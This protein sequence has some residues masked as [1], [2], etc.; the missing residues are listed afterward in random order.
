MLAKQDRLDREP[1]PRAGLASGQPTRYAPRMTQGN[2]ALVLHAHLPFVRHPEHERFLEEH[3]LYEAVTDT[4]LPLLEIMEGWRRDGL[5]ARLTLSVSPTLGAMLLDPL[6]QE[7]TARHLQRLVTLAERERQRTRWEP[8]FYALAEGYFRR[9]TE[10]RARFEACGR[11]LMGGWRRLQEAGVLELMTTAATHAIL[12][13]LQSH[14]PSLRAQVRVA[15]AAHRAAFGA[16]PRGMWLPECAYAPGVDKELREAGVRWF[17]VDSHGLLLGEP[18]PRY[19]VFAPVF[20]PEGVA[21]FGR[22]PE[23]AK[24]VWSREEGYPGDGRYRDFYR[25]IGFDLDLD[26]LADVLPAPGTRS[27]TG[28]KYH[29]VTGR[30]AEKRPYDR[31]AAQIAVAE[32][33]R[34]FVEARVAQVERLAGV[35]DRP[36]MLVAPYDAELF[37]HWWHEGLE[38]L[39]AVVRRFCQAERRVRLVT[40]SEFLRDHPTQQISQPAAS[41]WGERGHLGVWVNESNAWILPHLHMAQERMTELAGRFPEATGQAER[42]LRQAARELLLAQASDWPFILRAGTSPEYA[43][44]RV[45]EHL[46]RFNALYEQL[47]AGSVDGD[48]LKGVEAQDNLFPDVEWREWRLE[49]GSQQGSDRR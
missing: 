10:L 14:A 29:A 47:L 49:E 5:G 17:I 27:F 20:T 42:A 23:S 19:R 36:P 12:P 28:I 39:D 9:F 34:H 37:G 13:L 16:E 30:G 40:P 25:D 43:R 3:W 15:R 32:H 11:N 26:Y 45:E 22:D 38:F 46:V 21:A 24:Q 44:G 18:A 33:A 35:M 31:A 41:S 2:L 1:A 8:A 7:R 48:W 4:Y 6:L